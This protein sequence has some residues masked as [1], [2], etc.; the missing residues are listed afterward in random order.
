MSHSCLRNRIVPHV[1]VPV[2][3]AVPVPVALVLE[4]PG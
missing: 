4:L 1:A 2:A 3:V